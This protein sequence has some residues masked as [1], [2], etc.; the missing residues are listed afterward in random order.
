MPKVSCHSVRKSEMCKPKPYL[1]TVGLLV[2]SFVLQSLVYRI[3][4]NER[5]GYHTDCYDLSPSVS[6]RPVERELPNHISH[7]RTHNEEI[8]YPEF[9]ELGLHQNPSADHEQHQP[10]EWEN[11]GKHNMSSRRGVSDIDTIV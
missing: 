3:L 10:M 2:L 1:V 9:S 7:R 5:A 6:T 11:T 8:I 4:T